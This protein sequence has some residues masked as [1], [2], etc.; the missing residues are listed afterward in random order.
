MSFGE[1]VKS[2][3]LSPKT[4]RKRPDLLVKTKTISIKPRISALTDSGDLVYQ[5]LVTGHVDMSEV[6]KIMG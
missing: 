4:V 2:T 5:L 6:Q 1:L 3:G